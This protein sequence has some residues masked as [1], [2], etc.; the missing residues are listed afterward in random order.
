MLL[1]IISFSLLIVTLEIIFD[2]WRWRQG[3]DDK[4]ASTRMRIAAWALG[5]IIIYLAT[6]D[7][8]LTL[9]CLGVIIAVFFAVFD[10]ALNVARWKDLPLPYYAAFAH[11]YKRNINDGFDKIQASKYAYTILSPKQKREYKIKIFTGRLFWHGEGKEPFSY[12]WIFNFIPP[13]G[14]LLGKG[15]VLW[16]SIYWY[17]N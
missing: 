5:S 13:Q 6:K 14:E 4:P 2:K 3:K 16:M 11:A 9:A 12:D 10:F 7:I 1:I 8:V 17:L 15:I